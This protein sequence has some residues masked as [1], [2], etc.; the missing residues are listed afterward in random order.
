MARKTYSQMLAEIEQLKTQA[1]E[2]RRK[3][4]EEVIARIKSAIAFYGL[5]EEDLGFRKRA[6]KAAPAP[7][8]PAPAKKKKRKSRYTERPLAGPKN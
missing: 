5:T 6:E 3:E 4:V 1:E 7:P 2:V 8:A